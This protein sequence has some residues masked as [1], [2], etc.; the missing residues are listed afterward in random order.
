MKT[1]LGF[2]LTGAAKPRRERLNLRID[3][4]AVR[5]EAAR[6]AAETGQAIDIERALRA[7]V[8]DDDRLDARTRTAAALALA[9]EDLGGAG[10]P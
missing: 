5:R 2:L 7:A 4:E 6:H 10:N 1:P 3:L 8:A 9:Q